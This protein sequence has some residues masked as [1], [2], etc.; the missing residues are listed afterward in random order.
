[1][2]AWLLLGIFASLYIL[3]IVAAVFFYLGERNAER[4]SERRQS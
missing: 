4:I 1:M 3:L 2:N